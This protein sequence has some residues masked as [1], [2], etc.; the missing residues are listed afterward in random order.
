[1]IS[2]I[3]GHYIWD[4]DSVIILVLYTWKN[5][6]KVLKFSEIIMQKIRLVLKTTANNQ[7]FLNHM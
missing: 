2:S 5:S 3:D 4:K 1:M 7:N 6:L